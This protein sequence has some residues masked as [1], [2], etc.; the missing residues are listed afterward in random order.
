MLC[1]CAREVMPAVC[2]VLQDSA[3]MSLLKDAGSAYRLT[4]LYKL[5]RALLAG[6]GTLSLNLSLQERDIYN[7]ALAATP[8]LS[9]KQPLP[10]QVC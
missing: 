10:L 4:Q 2:R 8:Y 1:V 9:N 3:S 7:I 5:Q 6:L